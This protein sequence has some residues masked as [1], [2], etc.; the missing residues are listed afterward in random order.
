MN[1]IINYFRNEYAFL[2]NFY[3]RR[4]MYDNHLFPSSEHAYHYKKSFDERY[5]TQLMVQEEIDKWNKKMEEAEYL[6][7]VPELTPMEAKKYGNWSRLVKKGLHR[8]DWFKVSLQIMYDINMAKFT[9]HKD[10]QEKLLTTGSSVLIEGNYWNVK[11]WGKCRKDQH[12][13]ASEWVG[14][15]N[16]GKILMAVRMNIRRLLEEN[17]ND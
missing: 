16:L 12:D 7:L 3:R 5:Q 11:F 15:N 4:I 14:E 1:Y 13:P 2:S 9:Q 8:L 6:C 17:E 10:L